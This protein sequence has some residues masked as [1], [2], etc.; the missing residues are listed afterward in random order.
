MA[1]PWIDTEAFGRSAALTRAGR[2]D[3]LQSARRPNQSVVR[4]S[5]WLTRL[6]ASLM[7]KGFRR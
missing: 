2:T 3:V 4:S 5:A 6:I 7:P 1:V